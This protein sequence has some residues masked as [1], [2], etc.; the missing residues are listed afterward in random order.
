M[1]N[2]RAEVSLA[3]LEALLEEEAVVMWNGVKARDLVDVMRLL[4]THR[5]D[6][7]KEN[8]L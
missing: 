3:D 8:R 7:W 5:A 2:Y 6:K 1:N 4:E